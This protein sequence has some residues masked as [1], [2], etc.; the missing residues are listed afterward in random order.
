MIDVDKIK[1]GDR[2][3][4]IPVG[5]SDVEKIVTVTCEPVYNDVVK[6]NV[7][8]VAELFGL[9]PIGSLYELSD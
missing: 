9:C 4:F 7:V 2:Y 5:L 8:K 6:D 3:L 1:K